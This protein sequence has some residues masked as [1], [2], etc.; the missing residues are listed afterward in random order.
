MQTKLSTSNGVE[1]MSFKV[2]VKHEHILFGVAEH[3]ERCPV[4]LALQDQGCT[5]VEVCNEE[6]SFLSDDGTFYWQGNTP[7]QVRAFIDQFD[8]GNDVEPFRFVLTVK[9]VVA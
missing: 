3:C 4:A 5:E 9:R 1:K 2:E 6:I 8:A 7:G